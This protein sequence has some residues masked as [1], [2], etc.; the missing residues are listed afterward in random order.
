MESINEASKFAGNNTNMQKPVVILCAN[1]E[2][3][4]NEIR[5]TIPFVVAAKRIKLLRINLIKEWQHMDREIYKTLLKEIKEIHVN[6]KA[7]CVNGLENLI[8]HPNMMYRFN[9]NLIKIIMVSFTEMEKSPLNSK[10]QVT[11]NAKTILTGKEKQIWNTDTSHLQS[12]LQIFSVHWH[13]HRHIDQWDRTESP[14][15]NPCIYG[16]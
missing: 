4:K 10:F 14:E 7:Y 3:C 1:K 9:T 5:K 13:K 8:L 16:N 6:E 2:Q 12:L 11:L 15:I